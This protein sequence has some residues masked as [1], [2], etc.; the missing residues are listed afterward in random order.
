M[1]TVTITLADGTE[2]VF[3]ENTFGHQIGNGA[4]QIM[5]KSGGQEIYNNFQKVIITPNEKEQ[6]DFEQQVADA[7]AKAK[8]MEEAAIASQEAA[9]DEDEDKKE[10][11]N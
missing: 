8:E 11:A 10:L 1:S 7:E 2:K 5:L 6:A 4:V 9:N 3:E